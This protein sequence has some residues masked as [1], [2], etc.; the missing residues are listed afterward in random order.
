MGTWPPRG[1]VCILG[2]RILLHPAAALLVCLIAIVI[3]QF[4]GWAGLASAFPVVL[5]AA[6]KS[7]L[8]W[9]N[10]LRRMRWLLLSVWLILGYGV[11]GDAVFDLVW[12][13]THQGV[14]EA[15][16]HVA[17]LGLMLGC[18]ASLFAF[19][20]NQGLLVALRSLLGPLARLGL[21]TDRLVVR[22]S[23]VMENLRADL[24]KN[25][26]RCMLDGS[27]E[28]SGGPETLWIE[29]LQWRL[30]DYLICVAALA[31]SWFAIS[32]G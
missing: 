28:A 6:R 26:W 19:L 23:L 21:A 9:W 22:L 27:G 7:V 1:A 5:L 17:R 16:L 4:L 25:S 24:P 13:P 11:S 30:S 18:L 32:L 20:G 8:G 10:L 14:V 29:A 15:N 31:F 2:G 12:M 3:I